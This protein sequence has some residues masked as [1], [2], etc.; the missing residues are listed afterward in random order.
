MSQVIAAKT[1]LQENRISISLQVDAM[2]RSSKGKALPVA[3]TMQQLKERERSL[4][5]TPITNQVSEVA[6]KC[7]ST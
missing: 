2:A 3:P 1:I 6:V 5:L 7:D 4:S